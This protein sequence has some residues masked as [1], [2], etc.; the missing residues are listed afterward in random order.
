MAKNFLQKDLKIF[1][2]IADLVAS[3]KDNAV[4]LK[5]FL[6]FGNIKESKILGVVALA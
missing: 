3:T 5:M 6:Y 1:K 2:L 4:S